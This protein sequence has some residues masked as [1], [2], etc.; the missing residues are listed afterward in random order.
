MVCGQITSFVPNYSSWR[1]LIGY[2]VLKKMDVS[3]KF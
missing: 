3:Q 1:T 2:N